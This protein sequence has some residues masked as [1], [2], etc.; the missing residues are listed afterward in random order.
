MNSCKQTFEALTQLLLTAG[1]RLQRTFTRHLAACAL[2]LFAMPALA[3]IGGSGSI[4]GTVTD[5]TGAVI[6]GAQVV[7]TNDATGVQTKQ[8]ATGS[9]TFTL[10]PL[11]PG[12]Y[13]VL[14]SAPAFAELKQE[15]VQVDALQVVGL[16]PQLRPGGNTEVVTV[17]GAPPQLDTANAT[18]GGTMENEE[19]TSLPLQINGGA[20]NPTAFVYLEPG[21]ARGGSGVQTGI[22]NGTGSSGPSRRGLHRWLPP[23][24]HLRAGRPALRLQHH[25]RRSRRSVS[26]HHQQPAG[27]VPGR[28]PGELRHQFRDESHPRL[29][30]RLPTAIPRSIRG[31]SSRNPSSTR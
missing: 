27:A 30:L 8:T 5:V 25:L 24:Q 3:Q 1:E 29:G 17:E 20:R 14:I 4:T 18:V 21:V 23:D 22:F 9:G 13:T 28:R 6:P 7:A 12:S 19:Y 26:G 15:H 10:S 16:K 2:L 11:P 31:A